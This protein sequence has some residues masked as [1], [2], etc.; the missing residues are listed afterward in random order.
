MFR[1]E[2]RSTR[3]ETGMAIACKHVVFGFLLQL[4]KLEALTMPEKSPLM[5]SS[6]MSY[7]LHWHHALTQIAPFCPKLDLWNSPFPWN[8]MLCR[9]DGRGPGRSNRTERDS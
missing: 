3:N 1:V 5:S 8:L 6:P 2:L 4:S 7:L 9:L